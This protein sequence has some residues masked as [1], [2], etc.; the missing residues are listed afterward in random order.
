MKIL[1]DL[2]SCQSK[3]SRNRG[4]GNYSK[5]LVSAMLSANSGAEFR[6]VLNDQLSDS[7]DE[8]RQYFGS[9]I[10]PSHVAVW[11]GPRRTSSASPTNEARRV[12]A[13]TLRAAFIDEVRP[14]VVL[15]TSVFEGL[16]DDAVVTLEPS[17]RALLQSAIIYDLIPLTNSADYLG[18]VETSR[19]YYRQLQTLKRANL[20]CAISEH[21]RQEAIERLALSPDRIV[22]ISG[23]VSPAFRQILGPPDSFDAVKR[24]YGLSRA[25]VMYTGGFDLRKNIDGLIRAYAQLSSAIR[26]TRQL[27][28][29]CAAA[30]NERRK[31]G[32]LASSLGLGP[33]EV[34]FCGYVPEPDLAILYNSC[35]LFVFP[36]LQEGFGLPAL[37]AMSCGAATIAAG[38]SSIP[39][40]VGLPEALFDASQPGAIARKMSQALSD[41][42]FR[43][44]LREHGLNQAA[45]FSWAETA[46]RTLAALEASAVGHDTRSWAGVRSPSAAAPSVAF[47]GPLPPVKSGIAGYASELL[48]ELAKYYD[49]EVVTDQPEISDPWIEANFPRLNHG[50]FVEQSHRFDRIIYQ[51]GNSEF[52]IEMP[53][54]VRARPGV[55]VLHDYFLRLLP[56]QPARMRRIS[57]TGRLRRERIGGGDGPQRDER[58]RSW[59]RDRRHRPLSSP[60]G[61]TSR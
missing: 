35:D 30:D 13:Q 58:R 34:V 54:L 7:I 40:V 17:D 16:N 42:P 32:A 38:N 53:A 48:R 29:V 57:C 49:I 46:R 11:R 2:Q 20:L 26:R 10:D 6:I 51:M 8:I 18:N 21:S 31:M 60:A 59:R 36:S 37:E 55:V 43:Q 50:E 23:A 4:I 52:H 41:D 33:D 15:A 61:A 45:K 9:V 44:H 1:I 28:V 19:W 39:E 47:V 12:M 56:A 24:R 3:G 5:S 25:F 14:D 27:A 22:N